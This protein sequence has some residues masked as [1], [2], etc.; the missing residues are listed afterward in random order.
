MRGALDRNAVAVWR[1]LVDE[2]RPAVTIDVGAN[3]GEVSFCTRYPDTREMHLVEPNPAVLPWL[4]RT[5][6]ECAEAYP[7]IHLHAAAASDRTGT[8]RLG[9]AGPHSGTAS[10]AGAGA[11]TI[12]VPTFRL[13]ERIDLRAGDSLLFKVDVEG[14]ERSVLEG[15]SGLLKAGEAVGLCE[16]QRA[17]D[18][19]VDYLCGNFAV[20]VVRAGYEIP[21][22]ARDLRA[23]VEV[24]EATGWRHLSKDVVLR[25][26]G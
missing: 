25:P 7:P 19:L 20:H 2:T 21:V 22:D 3:Y 17:D 15:M 16:V 24:G 10:L 1:R 11:S 5:V 8:A 18:A 4:R 26:A 9:L 6:A 14:H 12:E 13:D 23:A